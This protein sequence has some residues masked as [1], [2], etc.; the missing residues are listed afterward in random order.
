MAAMSDSLLD[1]LR[2][3]T[4][5][6]KRLL[7]SC[8]SL[9]P[10]QLDATSVGTYGSI[11]ATLQHIIGAEGRYRFRLTGREPDWLGQP[12]DTEDLD[13]L[14]RMAEDMGRFWDGLAAGD[15]DPDR[16]VSWVSAVSGAHTEASAGILV[17]QTLN[18]GN[19]HRGQ[20]STI[21]TTMGVEPPSLDAWSYAM[22]TGRFRE[23]PPRS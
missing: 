4:W 20:I 7:G 12:E 21:L 5:A 15:F 1:P 23:T 8:R 9:Q 16:V 6:T 11:L 14:E 2:H 22:A 17:A 19:E 18:H 3:N 10:E 13:E